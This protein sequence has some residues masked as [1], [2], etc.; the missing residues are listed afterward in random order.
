M[1]TVESNA[2]EIERRC[3]MLK[4]N[5][6]M[7]GGGIL[8]YDGDPNLVTNGNT[9]G[10]TLIYNVAQGST[11]MQSD[12]TW[13]RKSTLPNTWDVVG[14]GAGSG[15]IVQKSVAT[16][17]TENIYSLDLSNNQVFD[18]TIHVINTNTNEVS[19]SKI[20]ALYDGT[21]ITSTEYATLGHVINFTSSIYYVDDN[22]TDLCKFDIY[23]DEDN[24]ITVNIKL[25][26]F[27]RA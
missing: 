2:F 27:N 14:S 18:W 7:P 12:G 8:G 23:N 11:F 16:K 4:F 1:A 6:N 24:E 26:T 22:G 5:T 17:Q 3:I 15:S 25:E 9:S 21:T 19:F 20:S 13:W 10:E